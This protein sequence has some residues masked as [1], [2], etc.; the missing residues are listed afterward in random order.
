MVQLK[1]GICEVNFGKNP[2]MEVYANSNFGY[3][4]VM[5]HT[6]VRKSLSWQSHK[7]PR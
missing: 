4:E 7:P 5:R 6:Y 3:T 2:K 1:G